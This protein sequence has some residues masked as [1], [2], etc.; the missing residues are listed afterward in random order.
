MEVCIVYCN[1]LLFNNVHTVG[2]CMADALNDKLCFCHIHFRRD[3]VSSSYVK[4][5]L[6]SPR[7]TLTPS[8]YWNMAVPSGR[9]TPQ[10]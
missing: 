7:T 4:M 5:I 6:R 10:M 9:K 2:T 3:M 8:E 1:S